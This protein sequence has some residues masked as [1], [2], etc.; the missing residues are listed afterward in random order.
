MQ[1]ILPRLWRAV[2]FRSDPTRATQDG[3]CTRTGSTGRGG[4]FGISKAWIRMDLIAPSVL[5]SPTCLLRETVVAFVLCEVRWG[6][7]LAAATKIVL[8]WLCAVPKAQGLT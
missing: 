3:A 4:V 8:V 2:L 5:F 1:R 7:L 6:C